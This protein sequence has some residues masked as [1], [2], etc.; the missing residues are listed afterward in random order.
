MMTIKAAMVRRMAVITTMDVPCPKYEGIET[1]DPAVIAWE[2]I[3]D[4]KLRDATSLADMLNPVDPTTGLVFLEST[5]SA[6]T[7][8]TGLVELSRPRLIKDMP[9][10]ERRRAVFGTDALLP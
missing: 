7:F 9:L 4:T 8:V 3:I 6:S 10:Y 5:S 1:S 2:T